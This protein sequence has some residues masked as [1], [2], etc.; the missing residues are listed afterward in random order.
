MKHKSKNLV[1]ALVYWSNS[2]ST[3]YGGDLPA[4]CHGCD[5]SINEITVL[6]FRKNRKRVQRDYR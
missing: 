6:V 3:R 4:L 2:I 5:V 1:V